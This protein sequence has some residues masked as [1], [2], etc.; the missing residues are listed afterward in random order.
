MFAAVADTSNTGFN[1]RVM[2]SPD[3]IN[4]TSQTPPMGDLEAICWSPELGLFVAVAYQY[5]HIISSPDGINWAIETAAE[6]NFFY[7]I[8]WSPAMRR[9][10]AVSL[11]GVHHAQIGFRQLPPPP[12]RNVVIRTA[13]L[14]TNTIR[15]K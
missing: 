12:P 4:W 2:T 9:F 7:N 3:G 6:N 1:H 10:V 11:D 13:K 5:N 8:C 14:I 15:T